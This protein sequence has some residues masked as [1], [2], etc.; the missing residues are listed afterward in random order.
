MKGAP[1]SISDASVICYTPIDARHRAT[2]KTRHAVGGAVQAAVPGLAICQYPED[3]GFYLF[4]CDAEWAP[5]TDTWHAS[6]E[7]AKHQA[8]FEYQGSA[9]TWIAAAK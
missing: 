2:G 1:A 6:I 4:Y 8:E 5:I 3:S 7:E 9:A